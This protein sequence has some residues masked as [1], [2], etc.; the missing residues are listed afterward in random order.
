MKKSTVRIFAIVL[1]VLMCLSL[2]PLAAAHAMEYPAEM[3]GFTLIGDQYVEN[4]HVYGEIVN[5]DF[6]VNPEERGDCETPAVYWKSCVN[7]SPYTQERCGVTA[8]QD[9]SEAMNRLKT[10]MAQRRANNEQADLES[11]F[12]NAI[13]DLDQKYKFSYG[14]FGHQWVEVEYQP[15][16][17]EQDGWETYHYCSACGEG[18][19]YIPLIPA[20]GHRYED[21]IC[22]VCGKAD[23]DYAPVASSDNAPLTLSDSAGFNSELLTLDNSDELSAA[24][25]NNL[26][27]NNTDNNPN[28]K[29][30]EPEGSGGAPNAGENITIHFHA[31][32]GE[33]E[34]MPTQVISAEN[35]GNLSPNTYTLKNHAFIGWTTSA[36]ASLTSGYFSDGQAVT[37]VDFTGTEVD[38]Y[39]RW[40]AIT[41]SFDGNF[42][43]EG[44]TIGSD[45]QGVLQI[46]EDGVV[47]PHT[48]TEGHNVISRRGGYQFAGWNTA[49][50]GASGMHF[51][52]GATVTTND[53]K[54]PTTLYAEWRRII[55]VY[56]NGN[57]GGKSYDGGVF[58][59]GTTINLKTREEAGISNKPNRTFV[60]WNTKADGSGTSYYIPSTMD[61]TDATP[62]V[63][64]L[65]AQWGFDVTLDKNDGSGET[66]TEMAKEKQE[67]TVPALPE[68]F[69]YA[70]HVFKNW[71]TKKDGN[72]TPYNP[73][74]TIEASKMLNPFT[75]Y[76][77]WANEY[78]ITFNANGGE[79]NVP[80][81]I[82]AEEGTEV[83][84]P[85]ANLTRTGYKF[86]GWATSATGTVE[87]TTTIPASKMT[88]NIDLFAHW[89]EMIA[90]T[91]DANDGSGTS[92]KTIYVELHDPVTLPENNLTREGF[93]PNGWNTKADG[94][95]KHY[96]DG[97]TISDV[98][99]DTPLFAEWIQV[100]SV[101][102]DTN[103][104]IGTSPATIHVN[105]NGT[106]EALPENTL[107]RDGYAPNGWNTKADGTGTH[108]DAGDTI[109]NVTA[110]IP[111]YAEWD[112]L[113]TV[114]FNRYTSDS[115][116]TTDEQSIRE[117]EIDTATLTP[118]A[119]LDFSN[120][121]KVFEGWSKT[122]GGALDFE[123]Q[124][125]IQKSDF[126]DGTLNL[127]ARWKDF[128]T[129]TF[130]KN[131]TAATGTMNPMK[132]TDEAKP[133][134]A[135]AFTRTGYQF[136][137]WNTDKNG[138][139]TA[140][141]DE[142]NVDT[143]V[144]IADVTLY[145]QWSKIFKIQYMSNGGSGIMPN[146]E[147]LSGVELE[148]AA[149]GFTKT[150]ADFDS[151]NTKA[152]GSGTTYKAGD[153]H[154]FKETDS[155][156]TL[157]AQWTYPVTFET[158]GGTGYIVEGN[159]DKAFEKQDYDIPENMSEGGE[160]KPLIT[161]TGY[162]FNG[163]NT[164]ADG[165][166]DKYADGGT[167]PA[168]KVTGPFKLY[169]QWDQEYTV[170]FKNTADASQTMEDQVILQSA[171][172]KAG[173]TGV[174]LNPNT[175]TYDGHVFTG[176]SKNAA[177]TD[178]HF[179]DG[180]KVKAGDFDSYAT[181]TLYA[182]WKDEV[183]ITFHRNYDTTLADRT[184]S[185]P[186]KT[187]AKLNPNTYARQ[188]YVFDAWYTSPA[189][190]GDR[191]EDGGTIPAD[192]VEGDIELYAHWI[193][194]VEISGSSS[195]KESY[196]YVGETLTCS[197]A[198]TEK[199]S[200]QWV[201]KDALT[202]TSWKKISGQTSQTFTPT[203][204]YIGK[205]VA[206]AA[207]TEDAEGEDKNI[208]STNNKQITN[209]L[210]GVAFKQ[211]LIDVVNEQAVSTYAQPG[212]IQ[213]VTKNM[214]Y[215]TDGGY[216]WSDVTNVSDAGVMSVLKP[217]TYIFRIKGTTIESDP[218]VIDRWFTFSYTTSN[219]TST[220]TSSSGNTSSSTGSG[221]VQLQWNGKSMPTNTSPT[222]TSPNVVKYS[223]GT[224]MW[225]VREGA[226]DV[227]TMTIR[228]SSGSYGHWNINGGS[229][230]NVSSESTITVTPL[231]GP[232]HYN[233]IFNRSSSS[234]RTADE[235]HLGLWS[236]LCLISL[237]GAAT[238]LGKTFKRKKT[239]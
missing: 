227:I 169:A 56:Y 184:Q 177:G 81:D 182:Q 127:Y 61:L 128:A 143:S 121:G 27:N 154:T 226:D 186:E 89:V 216:S 140:F 115:D 110:D 40:V 148:I 12:V 10:E 102:F 67:F 92:P 19:D 49:P 28:N 52:D 217:G 160:P 26:D 120:S 134:T 132:V 209:K 141:E 82:Y 181:L 8:E 69:T 91:F 190:T 88:G 123:D 63:V 118:F 42:G 3:P 191:Y 83:L 64:T 168:S 16:T 233:I 9:W 161:R 60:C 2:L 208:L 125:S 46:T 239:R 214:Q 236:A 162:A 57:D 78:K 234:P 114:K 25:N 135:N 23:P 195:E 99:A 29:N 20:T 22:A 180:A 211:D 126:T 66:K 34:E 200:L 232:E 189:G 39:A 150:G 224:N 11:I 84:L 108:Y 106:T 38:L 87:Y 75:L 77:R 228:P 220:S 197:I 139:G 144:I 13:T 199:I 238:I 45:F 41:V 31:N 5:E 171:F 107:T 212:Q 205:Y 14:G 48:G 72:G 97:A 237:T 122:K 188:G 136:M 32:G 147:A 219:T 65:Y 44:G 172:D 7:V 103:K 104:G 98:S 231:N 194:P 73:N 230:A 129:I 225:L 37:A 30:D 21:G 117:S 163:W 62:S 54:V 55:T 221:T 6:L 130:D 33:G 215:S 47:L 95:G 193:G 138:D 166:G 203:S 223:G 157:Y 113:Y 152:D 15:A 218:V 207:V 146:Q 105:K 24:N 50:D 206:C 155:D 133:L 175:F 153:K 164:K 1:V 173:A 170:S 198:P 185:V 90:V 137:G 59:P 149:N 179:D 36:D 86:D 235:S 51:E 213:G 210:T 145:A 183:V 229:Y 116:T 58:Y 70:G 156:L 131:S 201:Y 124:A 79:G 35:G 167:V 109:S 4:G 158:N 76:A 187:D 74:D 196:G 178:G 112:K 80:N 71:N 204:A 202:D 222:T 94:T 101:S 159:T 174:A 165:T 142:E 176:W 100:F 85:E 43:S 119:E 93:V 192:K 17:C 96:D 18:L 68:D 111:L 53:I 151:W